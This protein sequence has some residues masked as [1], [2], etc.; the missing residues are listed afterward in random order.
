VKTTGAYLPLQVDTE[1]MVRQRLESTLDL[2]R[3]A[4][5]DGGVG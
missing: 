4:L 5:R 3:T 1:A 2:V